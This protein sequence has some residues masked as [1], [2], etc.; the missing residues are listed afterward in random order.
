M[1][2]NGEPDIFPTKY[3]LHKW[4]EDDGVA[5]ELRHSTLTLIKE[6]KPVTLNVI[7]HLRHDRHFRFFYISIGYIFLLKKQY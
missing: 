6:E 1:C 4:I 7:I 2:E 5:A 3:Q